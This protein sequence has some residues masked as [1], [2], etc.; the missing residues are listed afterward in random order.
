MAE[1]Q[2][3]KQSQESSTLNSGEETAMV[4]NMAYD[5]ENHSG[6]MRP[7]TGSSCSNEI[8]S[9]WILKFE[10]W[11]D[12]MNIKNEAEKIT[13][14]KLKTAKLKKIKLKTAKLIKPKTAFL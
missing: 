7:F 3:L 2:T 4:V 14:L 6:Q 13:K 12:S 10:D 11:I 1:S 9:D 5:N 8:F